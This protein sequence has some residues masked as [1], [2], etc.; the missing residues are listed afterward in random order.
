MEY[1]L[2]E[3]GA[4]AIVFPHF[5]TRQQ[6]FIFRAFEFVTP[7]KIA[8]ILKTTPENIV[9]AAA[10]MGLTAPCTGDIWLE[11]GY[12]TII[13]SLWHI[14]PY[15]QLMELLETDRASF[16]KL[17]RE[18]DFLDIK[19]G[20]QK[21]I[22]EPLVWR[23]LTEEEKKQTAL[24]RDAMADVNM[25]G[26]APFDFSYAAPK[27]EFSGKPL[28]GNRMIYG[29]SSLYQT[30]LDADSESYCPDEMLRA[31]SNLGINALWIPTALHD[32][33]EFP[34]D[35]T[36]SAG[37]ETRLERL[38]H[39]SERCDAFG[40][41]LFIYLN[42][43]R[44][45]P[46]E[47]Y[48]KHP[49]LRGHKVSPDSVCLCTSTEK[50][51]RYLTENVAFVCRNVPKLG[52]IFTIT[53]SEN[54]T[55]CYSHSGNPNNPADRRAPCTCPR[56][57]K[58]TVGEVIGE[59][60]ACYEKGV[61]SAD[62][63]MKVIVWS[64]SWGEDN[65]DIIAHLPDNVILQS[66]SEDLKEFTIGG[67]SGRVRDYSM[68]IVG[69]GEKAKAEWRA[70]KARG[71]EVSAKVQINTT[72]E[73]STV[74]AVPVYPLI[75]EHMRN[76]RAEGVDHIM[77]SWTLGGYPSQNIRFAA[78]Y[79]FETCLT[80][81]VETESTRKATALFSEAF[82]QFPFD[83]GVLYKG[84]QNGGVS[85]L[86][87]IEPTGYKATMTCYAYDDLA[88]WRSIYPEDVFEDQLKKL[89]DIWAE[90]LALLED[91]GS[92]LY[93]MAKAA[94][95]QFSAC[96]NQVRFCRARAVGDSAA[97]KRMAAMEA[98]NAIEMLALM[99]R[100]AVIGFE[101]ANHYYFSK[102]NLAEKIVNCRDILRRL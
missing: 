79:F 94:F 51:Q 91:D 76:L 68:S 59:V 20:K 75:E 89:C 73:A 80:P 45:L 97:M 52:G 6:A 4:D 96:L 101:A 81:P 7:E 32:I 67:V 35:K 62:P 77:L 49:A 54:H 99:N 42:E 56:C 34:F 26:A 92:D 71:L 41:K 58:R 19:L 31:Y 53:R 28:F 66:N 29:F 55:N 69:P 98:E 65:L 25:R 14:L 5:P 60:A 87:F 93:L 61:H 83:I 22:C 86:L 43:P 17:L 48:E 85:N 18:E 84:P 8:A 57:S 2:P 38:R 63:D 40:M 74:P 1:H 95:I 88:S 102:G 33:S 100:T 13:R 70:A 72:W 3:M 24:I 90:G 12:I 50:V 82:R 11:K 27:M 9:R 46:E 16:A 78:K 21:P 23:E 30:A 47:F 37:Y 10:D 44:S 36:L 64:W 15:E 39:F